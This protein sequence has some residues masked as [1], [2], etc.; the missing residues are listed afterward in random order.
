MVRLSCHRVHL[1]FFS[2]CDIRDRQALIRKFFLNIR[3]H[4]KYIS[5]PNKTSVILRSLDITLFFLYFFSDRVFKRL[6]I[7]RIQK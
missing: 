6:C 4:M 2:F 5:Y 1:T 3:L 7:C